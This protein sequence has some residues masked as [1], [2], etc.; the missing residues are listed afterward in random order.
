MINVC[1][2]VSVRCQGVWG[3]I[4]YFLEGWEAVDGGEIL[5]R[6]EK[7]K[8]IHRALATYTNVHSYI[9][10]YFVGYL[11]WIAVWKE[12]K[13]AGF[14]CMFVCCVCCIRA[15]RF[16][17]SWVGRLRGQL[18]YVGG[19]KKGNVHTY[20]DRTRFVRIVAAPVVSNR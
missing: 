12:A 11:T 4:C 1:M 20:T 7:T 8:F 2:Y 14:E 9:N 18:M 13:R 16:F 5:P 6:G 19:V 3:L 17:L 15:R 10:G